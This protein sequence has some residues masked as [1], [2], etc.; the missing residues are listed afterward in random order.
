M[1]SVLFFAKVRE[2]LACRKLSVD[3]AEASTV[4]ALK[5]QLVADN[6]GRWQ[7]VLMADNIICALNQVVVDDSAA[8][9]NGDEVAFYPPVTGG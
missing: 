2:D 9:V 6:G 1:I 7:Q 5:K 4:S 8:I 3:L